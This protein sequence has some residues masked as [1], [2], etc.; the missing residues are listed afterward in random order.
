VKQANRVLI[1]RL[2]CQILCVTSKLIN[3]A[4]A[5]FHD[6]CHHQPKPTLNQHNIAVI[7]LV[8]YLNLPNLV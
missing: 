3:R 1:N 4:V 8:A 5:S 7:Y 6:S 2:I